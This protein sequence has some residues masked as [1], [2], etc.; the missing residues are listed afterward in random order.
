MQRLIRFVFLLA[1]LTFLAGCGGGGGGTNLVAKLIYES[2]WSLRNQAGGGLSQRVSLFDSNGRPVRTLTA[3]QD[4]IGIQRYE[5]A[6]L[7]PGKYRLFIELYSQA[8]LQGTRVGVIETPLS[9]TTTVVFRSAV[10]ATINSVVVNPNAITITV[11][12][13]QPLYAVAQNAAGIPT[14][15]DP[16]DYRWEAFGNVAMVDA[17]GRVTAVAEGSG[18]VRATHLPTNARGGAE[19][20]VSPFVP[21]HGK[22]TIIVFMNAANDLYSYS[23]PNMNQLEKVAQNADV[24]FVVQWKQAQNL[25]GGSTFEGTRRYLVKADQTSTVAS[26]LVQDLGS[27]IDMGR[28]DTLRNF[29]VW[30]KQ[31]YPADRY[32]LVIWNHGNG[33]RRTVERGGMKAAS[34]DDE[35][36]NAIQTWE[37]GTALQGQHF[38]FLAWD[39]SLMQM[40]EVAYECRSFADYQ[41]GSEE[42]PPAEGYPYDAVFARFRDNPDQ[43]TDTLCKAFVDGMMNVPGYTSRKITQS[44]LNSAK[45]DAIAVAL[46]QLA[47][48]LLVQGNS[49]AGT[50][51][52]IRDNA[53]T[54][55]QTA[56]RY[57]RDL[58]DVCARLIA[59]NLNPQIN[60]AAQQVRTALADALVYE[61]HNANSPGS[62]GLSIDFSPG[63]VFIGAAADY[64]RI[65][66]AQDS[67]WDD[68]LTVAP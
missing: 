9:I 3:E 59:A 31:Y 29:I 21:Q 45:L 2:D 64:S 39:C 66:L 11:P 35:T 10:G 47:I 52:S 17:K 25:F 41:V 68:W 19:V 5:M 38:D 33:W 40:L 61:R 36:G 34:Y 24:R 57:Y 4:T 62:R 49:I 30:A 16:A 44:V 43:P 60:S 12:E 8:G 32:G 1:F 46:D 28:P 15:S 14:F 7:T 22:W 65:Q 58:D 51:Q 42:S 13:S 27:G 23:T 67:K 56:I 63:S 50:I 6:D 37:M 54:Y 20:L 55:S 26:K 18:T 48:A 53:Q